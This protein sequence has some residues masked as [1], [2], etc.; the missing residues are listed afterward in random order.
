MVVGR[1]FLG[2]VGTQIIRAASMHTSDTTMPLTAMPSI[3]ACL[4]LG[5][6]AICANGQGQL[7][8]DEYVVVLLQ[9]FNGRLKGWQGHTR[10][11]ELLVC[12][13][14]GTLP[15]GL[16]LLLPELLLLQVS[17]CLHQSRVRLIPD[18]AR[19]VALLEK[20]DADLSNV[21]AVGVHLVIPGQR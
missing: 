11:S 5:R 21:S 8:N 7:V 6:S 20:L 4:P 19:F 17:D 16:I 13:W 2:Q 1:G 9:G 18:E 3:T 15:L 12:R 10:D 14:I